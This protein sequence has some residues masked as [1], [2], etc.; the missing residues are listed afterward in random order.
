MKYSWNVNGGENCTKV[1]LDHSTGELENHRQAIIIYKGAIFHVKSVVGICWK[2][3]FSWTATFLILDQCIQIF[4]FQNV[5]AYHKNPGEGGKTDVSPPS[6]FAGAYKTDFLGHA[7][8][9]WE[10]RE[11]APGRDS[12]LPHQRPEGWRAHQADSFLDWEL[13]GK[14]SATCLANLTN[15]WIIV[16]SFAGVSY[17]LYD[18]LN[19]MNQWTHLPN[20]RLF[21]HSKWTQRRR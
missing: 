2:R 15:Q 1:V 9:R 18:A 11:Q 20:P 6:F 8:M 5:M 7:A 12:I 16:P 10:L 21:I 4:S 19:K 13:H 3:G 17:Q 14:I